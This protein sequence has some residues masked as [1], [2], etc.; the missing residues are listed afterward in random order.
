[1][2]RYCKSSATTLSLREADTAIFFAHMQTFMN[3]LQEALNVLLML[4]VRI[5]REATLARVKMA[6]TGME[7]VVQV[8]Y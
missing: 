6:I 3:V 4:T 2:T 1:M 7:K 5:H 8:S